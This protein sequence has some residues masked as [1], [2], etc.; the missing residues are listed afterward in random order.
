MECAGHNMWVCQAEL[1][2]SEVAVSPKYCQEVCGLSCTECLAL[3]QM[4]F[5]IW[6]FV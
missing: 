6:H 3:M 4:Q 2:A 5:D 1:L